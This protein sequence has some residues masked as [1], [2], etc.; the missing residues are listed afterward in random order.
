MGKRFK[1]VKK[2]ATVNRSLDG[3]INGGRGFKPDR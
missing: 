1:P 2:K 3:Q